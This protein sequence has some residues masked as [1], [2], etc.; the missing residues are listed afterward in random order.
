MNPE[1][2]LILSGD[3][4]AIDAID[5]ETRTALHIASNTGT[6]DTIHLLVAQGRAID[7]GDKNS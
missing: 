6:L 7:A 1:F 2:S 5:E 4:A 3:G